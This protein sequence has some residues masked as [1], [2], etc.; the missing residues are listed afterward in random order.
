MPA[1]RISYRT[2]FSMVER[3]VPWTIMPRWWPC[4]MALPENS[5]SGQSSRRWK[6][7]Q[8]VPVTPR[9]PHFSTLTFLI[10]I[11]PVCIWA[12]CR[13]RVHVDLWSP[14]PHPT[15]GV[16]QG[17]W[18]KSSP[19][20]MIFLERLITSAVINAAL[21]V[22]GSSTACSGLRNHTVRCSPLFVKVLSKFTVPS[23]SRSVIVKLWAVPSLPFCVLEI[24]I[25]SP[26]CQPILTGECIN[27]IDISLALN[28]LARRDHVR[29]N[30]RPV[31]STSGP[32]IPYS[33]IPP[34]N[35]VLPWL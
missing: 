34:K 24:P 15:L 21:W 17:T 30:L 32:L 19:V 2:L 13:P 18:R 12:V 4:S 1:P 6:C 10:D 27:L 16:L 14:H 29:V 7:R 3:C 22:S 9:C 11:F 20:I 23:S 33:P 35:L 8:Y 31:I 26:T 5:Q 28:A 25:R